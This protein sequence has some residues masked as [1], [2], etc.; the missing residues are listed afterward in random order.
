MKRVR[1]LHII[2]HLPVGG[3]QDNTLITVEKLNKDRYDVTL[4]CGPEGEW[5]GRA[6]SIEGVKLI[7]VRELVRKIHPIYDAVA[8]YKLYRIIK[9]GRYAIVHTHSSKP[10][11]AGRIAARLARVPLVVHT[12]HGFPF[13]DFMHPLI[14]C[15]FVWIERFL[16]KFSDVLI[17]VS[18]LN[19]QK[20]I[21]LKL[22]SPDTFVNI[23]SGICFDRFEKRIDRQ[24][25]KEALGILPGEKVVGMVGRLS[26]QKAPQYLLHAM[27]RIL[28]SYGDVRFLL[29]GDGELRERLVSSAA[30]LGVEKRVIFLGFCEDIPE[31]LSI[32]DVF[33]LTSLWEGLGRSLTE[34]MYMGCPVVATRVEGVPE[35]VVHGETGI[36]VPPADTDAIARGVL[37]ML[38][39]EKRA[40]RMGKAA[41]ERVRTDFGAKQ[42]LGRIEDVYQS[43]IETTR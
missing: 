39:D 37:E 40:R 22:G 14:R 11:F 27:P 38:T 43:M 17:T 26:K 9:R 42:M 6:Q 2:T 32:L 12:I 25:K 7:Y 24:A 33:V 20:A 19:Q 4:I 34:A 28:Q 41:R 36:L 23:Y 21:D 5:I 35:I 18:M 29:V 16:S 13:H 1:I 3:A 31:I 8:L 10:G 15:F 30:R